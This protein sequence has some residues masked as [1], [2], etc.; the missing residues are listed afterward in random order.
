MR[1]IVALLA[2]VGAS[3]LHAEQSG[4]LP[5]LE[6]QNCAAGVDYHVRI[7]LP[8]GPP[9]AVQMRRARSQAVRTLTRHIFGS[10]TASVVAA[11]SREGEEMAVSIRRFERTDGLFR[12]MVHRGSSEGDSGLEFAFS[13]SFLNELSAVVHDL[14]CGHELRETQ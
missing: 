4:V 8:A 6:V 10:A 5:A 12:G 11:E 1:A 2:L 13:L 9:L 7:R 3:P 14:V